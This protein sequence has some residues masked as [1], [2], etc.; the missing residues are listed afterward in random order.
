MTM[1]FDVGRFVEG[2]A[3]GGNVGKQLYEHRF[4]LLIL[5]ILIKGG[6]LL[7]WTI[8]NPAICCSISHAN[9]SIRILKNYYSIPI[10]QSHKKKLTKCAHPTGRNLSPSPRGNSGLASSHTNLGSDFRKSLRMCQAESKRQISFFSSSPILR[11][12]QVHLFACMATQA[13]ARLR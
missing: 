7:L 13:A 10:F 1:V 4:I 6:K 8:T 11:M 12:E 2:G 5:C 3:C 9:I